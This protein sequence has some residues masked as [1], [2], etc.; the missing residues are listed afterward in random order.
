MSDTELTENTG[1]EGKNVSLVLGSGGARGLAHI[2]V[3]KV[4]EANGY[5]IRSICG[6]SMGA[7]IGGIYAA[8]RLDDYEKWVRAITRIDILKFMDLSWGIDGLV[9]GDK[10]I[11]TLIELV[12]DK[13]IEELP[14]KFTA[15]AADITNDREIW[16]NSGSLFKAIRAS[17]SLPLFL[18]PVP[19]K[20]TFLV[21]GGVLNPVPIAPTFYDDVDMTIAVDLSG[22][23]YRDDNKV[24]NIPS[25]PESDANISNLAALQQKIHSF[26]SFLGKDTSTNQKSSQKV[27]DIA[28]QAFDSM[29][30]TIARHKLAT[31]PPD[32]L[33]EI[34]RDACRTMEFHR[35]SE[36]ISL[37]ESAA[38]KFIQSQ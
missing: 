10:I 38:N 16:I 18:T 1:N 7:C 36:L 28:A 30:N 24:E 29:Q 31:Y 32:H 17:I 4:L 34:P 14:I 22:P 3:I 35:A 20:G 37:G 26:M 25:T 15:V 5:N 13:T 12:G 33:I 6:C 11:N 19:Y 9:K 23:S 2:G 27:F 8:G 21:D